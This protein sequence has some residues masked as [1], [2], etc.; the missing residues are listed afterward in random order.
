MAFIAMPSSFPL[1]PS[2]H[3]NTTGL[4]LQSQIFAMPVKTRSCCYST[5]YACSV[6]NKKRVDIVEH[7]DLI[8]SPLNERSMRVIMIHHHSSGRP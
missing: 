6:G 5:V 2:R 8:G 3:I 7:K 1:V 4:D